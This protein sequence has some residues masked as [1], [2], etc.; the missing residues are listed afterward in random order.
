MIFVVEKLFKHLGILNTY[1]LLYCVLG[2]LIILVPNNI[3]SFDMWGG[4]ILGLELR[5]C[6]GSALGLRCVTII[7]THRNSYTFTYDFHWCSRYFVIFKKKIKNLKT[8]N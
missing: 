4:V 6:V 1:Y 7:E 5:L 8:Q 3:V 2:F